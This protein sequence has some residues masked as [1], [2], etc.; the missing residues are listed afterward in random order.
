MLSATE[1]EIF[2]DF[3]TREEV[4]RQFSTQLI[5]AVWAGIQDKFSALKKTAF[6]KF[7]PFSSTYIQQIFCGG[8]F[9]HKR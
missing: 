7:L 5:F 4:K 6:R 2:I 1:D 8:C 9:E 3:I